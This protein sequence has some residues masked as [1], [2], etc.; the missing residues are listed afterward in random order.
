MSDWQRY[1]GDSGPVF[2]VHEPVTSSAA[3]VSYGAGWRG[4]RTVHQVDVVEV[5][6]V[7]PD[8][9]EGVPAGVVEARH[10]HGSGDERLG[11]KRSAE[12]LEEEQIVG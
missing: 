1:S 3:L 6:G 11:P 5:L 2:R 9:R 7:L 12:A 8:V 4:R 10:C